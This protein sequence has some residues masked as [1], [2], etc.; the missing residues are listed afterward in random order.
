MTTPTG[1]AATTSTGLAPNVSAALSYVLGPITGILFLVIEREN[2]YVRFHAAQS[3]AVAV[4]LIAAAIVLTILSSVLAFVPIL[5]WIIG[6]LLS[7]GMAFATFFLWLFLMYQAFQGRE[8]E[9]PFAG[10]LA[11]KIAP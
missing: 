11:R 7:L 6:L 4:I 1:P 2:K 5:G 8:W 9:A 10:S 3:I